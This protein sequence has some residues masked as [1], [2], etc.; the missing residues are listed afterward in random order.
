MYGDAEVT[1]SELN[2]NVAPVMLGSAIAGAFWTWYVI[3]VSLN[4][5][6]T[7]NWPLYPDAV[8]P[9]IRNAVSTSRPSTVESVVTVTVVVAVIPLPALILVIP[10]EPPVGPTIRYSSILVWISID[11]DG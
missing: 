7:T 3:W 10:T 5:W 9:S 2:D 11:E 4:L 1:V 8:I 6:V